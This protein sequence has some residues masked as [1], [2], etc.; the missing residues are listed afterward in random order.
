MYLRI[1]GR[2]E[3]SSEEVI[4]E[5]RRIVWWVWVDKRQASREVATARVD[6]KDLVAEVGTTVC[7]LNGIG[8]RNLPK[9]RGERSDM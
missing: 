4:E 2:V 6:E 3:L 1:I 5:D 7:H 9:N 8:Q